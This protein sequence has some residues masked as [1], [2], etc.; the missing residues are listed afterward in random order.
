M[1]VH[2]ADFYL[3]CFQLLRSEMAIGHE[4]ILQDS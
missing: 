1:E 4:K 2:V 3:M